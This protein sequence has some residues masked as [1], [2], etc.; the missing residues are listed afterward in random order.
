MPPRRVTGR[1]RGTPTEI[2]MPI[3]RTCLHCGRAFTVPPAEVRKGG[4]RYC[5][6]SCSAKHHTAERSA[7]WT[8]GRSLTANGYVRVT[9]DGRN[10]LE[11]RVV[12]EQ[13]IGRPL[14]RGEEVHHVNGDKSDNRPE[15]LEVLSTRE[16]KRRHRPGTKPVP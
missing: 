12:A 7:R 16:H 5:S 2:E 8:G 14:R 9:V 10:R 13:T 15:N 3:D 6:H 1:G 4:G 11:H